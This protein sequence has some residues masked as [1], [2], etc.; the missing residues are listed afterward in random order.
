MVTVSAA[1][2]VLKGF[3]LIEV[4][5]SISLLSMLMLTAAFA[6]S[7]INQNWQRGQALVN[8]ARSNYINWTLLQRSVEHTYPIF[9]YP[10]PPAEIQQQPLK[11]SFYFLGRAEGYTAITRNSMQQPGALAVYRLF[12]EKELT[13]GNSYQLVYEEAL[14]TQNNLIHA[15][16]EHN[17]NF[18]TLVS[19]GLTNPKMQYLVKVAANLKDA[20]Q[21]I[22]I[23]TQT[24]VS[25]RFNEFDGL[26]E[27]NHPYNIVI[28]TNEFSWHIAIPDPQVSTV[29]QLSE[30]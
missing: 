8:Q 10:Q 4:L 14:L 27:Y 17:F 19:V 28:T 23:E 26:V 24:D 29:D 20:G 25:K 18:R 15:K 21:R 1:R 22:D 30:F 9:V 16:Q 7:F 11:P 5:I 12:F 3:T 2:Q 13:E 6:Y